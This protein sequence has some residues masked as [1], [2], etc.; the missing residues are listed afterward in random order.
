[1]SKK[2]KF[3]PFNEEKHTPGAQQSAISIYEKFIELKLANGDYLDAVNIRSTLAGDI[4]FIGD[5]ERRCA[6]HYS[7]N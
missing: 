7:Y 5:V 2:S 3:V 6:D 4:A 1:M